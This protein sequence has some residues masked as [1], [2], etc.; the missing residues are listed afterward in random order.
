MTKQ[1]IYMNLGI[2]LATAIAFIYFVG[3]AKM[4]EDRNYALK[5]KKKL[6]NRFAIYFNNSIVRG[7][8]RRIVE[9][10]ASLSCYDSD[11]VKEE[12]VK[13][14]EK[15]ATIMVILP[16]VAMVVMRDAL[17]TIFMGFMGY[18]Y[19]QCYVEKEN[20]RIYIKL[21][22]ECSMVISSVREKYLETDS[23]PLSILYAE[24]S[25]LL[26]TPMNNVYRILTD[27]DGRDRLENFQHSYPVPIIKTFANTCY[28]VNEHGAVKHEN[29]SDSFCEDM[30]T[31]RQE[32]DAEIRRL[33]K[34]RIAFNSLQMLS[35]VGIAIM[36]IG[37]WY[38][39]NQIPGTASLL[40]G[41]YGFIIH[42]LIMITTMYAFR[43]IST[44]CRPSVVNT[45]DKVG[46]IDDLSKKK[47]MRDWVQK[48]QPKKYKT[49]MKLQELI[50]GS[51]S[52]QDLRYI[53]TAKPIYAVAC[54]FATL[55]VL[56]FGTIGVRD[57]FYNNYNS[58]SFIP[59]VVTETQ[60]N[61]I[62]RMDNDFMELS[63]SEYNGYT[64]EE[65]TRLIKSSITGCNDSDAANHVKRLRKKYEGYHGAK[66]YW[67]WWVVA[68]A[69]GVLGWHIPEIGLSTRHKMVQYEATND[70]S[71]LQT[72]M[73]VLSETKMDVYKS[74]CWLE[75]QAA[76][77]RAAI[78]KCHYS[79]IADPMKALDKLEVASPINDFKRLVRKLKSSVYT[80]SLK[81]AF[82]DMALDKAQT[83]TITELLRGEELELRKNSAKLIAI[84]PAAVA[85]IGCLV[86]PILILGVNEMMDTLNSL[87]GFGA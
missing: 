54:F 86:A 81:D 6:H 12:A 31:L 84:A 61:Q 18:V 62:I 68:Y 80:L 77:H 39:L 43:Y 28:I 52:S 32:C 70:V 59:S 58:L 5:R 42:V 41:Y 22:E 49:L 47:W 15:N 72:M 25:R 10:Y 16:I 46:F 24:K 64:D 1:M 21:M 13:L 78:R 3:K 7:P 38:L 4:Q 2:V 45:I 17:I 30:T 85:L 74:I 75:K 79:Y 20:D 73:I 82:S 60:Q 55:I 69:V 53:Y 67:W 37:E 76:V 8:F 26:E 87:S 51:L 14:F 36:P 83:L 63:K 44:S 34:Q 40:K 48:I 35:L 9:M 57:A 56:L 66:Y 33:T 71:Q 27:T 23:I 11:T 65:L 19:Y 50:N 29:G